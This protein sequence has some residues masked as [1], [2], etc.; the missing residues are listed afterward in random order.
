MDKK[1]ILEARSKSNGIVFY[2][3]KNPLICYE[4]YINEKG[5]IQKE[6][7][8]RGLSELKDEDLKTADYSA[9]I[10]KTEK[11]IK[12][13][14][15]IIGIISVFMTKK[16]NI[17]CGLMYFAMIALKDFLYFTESA[18]QLKCGRMQDLAKY[19]SAEHM[20]SNAYARVQRIPTIEEIKKSSR[21]DRYCS[22]RIYINKILIFGMLC[23][24]ICLSG[25]VPLHI[26]V[27]LVAALFTF[28]IIQQKYNI[29]RF[30]QIFCTKKPTD[31][32][33]K[34]AEE[35]IK[36]FE[37]MEEKMPELFRGGGFIICFRKTDSEED[38]GGS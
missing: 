23:I 34:V 24:V 4:V 10:Y 37:E 8:P 26:Y 15:A 17:A 13:A 30:L 32:E 33:L 1:S 12:I 25:F 9:K 7:I 22:S 18:Y 27:I 14:M 21:F 6:Q 3:N 2:S 35:G 5:E 28:A 31:K 20:V 36:Y 11:R 38:N 29:F 16:I 19:H